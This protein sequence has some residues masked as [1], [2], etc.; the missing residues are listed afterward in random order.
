MLGALFLGDLDPM[1]SPLPLFLV[2]AKQDVVAIR[3]CMH[4]YTCVVSENKNVL[5]SVFGSLF[6]V[7]DML[8]FLGLD[9]R[10]IFSGD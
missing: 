10:H 5:D 7:H 9:Y 4:A 3:T 2:C 6:L 1:V 8:T